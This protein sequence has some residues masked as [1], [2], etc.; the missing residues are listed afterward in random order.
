MRAHIGMIMAIAIAL[1]ACDNATESAGNGTLKVTAATSGSLPDGDGYLVTLADRP[2]AALGA[3]AEWSAGELAPGSY[4]LELTGVAAN[5]TIVGANP[6][7]IVV[8]S[9]RL[10]TITFSVYCP[11]PATVRFAVTTTGPADPDGY[12][13]RISPEAPQRIPANGVTRVQSL[14]AGPRR[15]ILSDVAP[16]CTPS[17]GNATSIDVRVDQ[18]AEVTLLVRCGAMGAL[19]VTVNGTLRARERGLLI[20]YQLY[21]IDSAGE[22]TIPALRSGQYSVY[23]YACQFIPRDPQVVTVE[24]GVT[25]DVALTVGSCYS[26]GF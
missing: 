3:N 23:G 11:T 25:T 19:H 8:E 1:G 14:P 15:L 7:T 9:G 22:V 2:G 5:C 26:G 4:T 13:I 10:A 20:D 6:R 21:A 17:R 16:D 18:P 12:L 24:P